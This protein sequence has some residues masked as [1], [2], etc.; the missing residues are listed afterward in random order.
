[1]KLAVIACAGSFVAA[2]AMAQS[3]LP[4]P[5]RTPGALN[6]SVTQETVAATI[7]MRGW[8]RTV[9]PPPAARYLNPGYHLVPIGL[10][11]APADPR[12]LW[13]EPRDPADD[14][15]A[16]RK[17]EPEAVL[18]RLVCEGRLPLAEAQSAIARDWIAAY[19][20]FVAPDE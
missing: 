8:T 19:R 1:M 14:W 4:D 9:R 6:P 17:D 7:C 2:A 18:N 20:R 3:S 13:P 10:G 12:N 11:G 15:G 5:A 16:D